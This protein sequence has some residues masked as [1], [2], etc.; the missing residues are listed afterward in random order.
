MVIFAC[1]YSFMVLDV[2]IACV[3]GFALYK[4]FKNG[5]VISLVSLVSLVAGVFI[6]L[7][8]SFLIR[9]WLSQYT[10][11][12][13]YSLTLL[14][15]IITFAGVLTGLY[16]LGRF[17]TSALQAMALGSINK[18]AGAFFEVLKTILI[19]SV[20]FNLFQKINSNQLLLSEKTMKQS[21]LYQ[22][23]ATT[24]IYLFPLMKTW[25][26]WALEKAAEK[27]IKKPAE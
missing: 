4:G 5:F 17:L 7:K 3:L 19:L 12:N 1:K 11:W 23:I 13:S 8:F 10:Q 25:Y 15:F 27:D 21:V 22:P 6:A 14:A 16:F 9:Q 24:S 26:N 18:L 20:L 2:L